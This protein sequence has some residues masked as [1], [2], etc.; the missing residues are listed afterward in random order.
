MDYEASLVEAARR[1]DAAA[2]DTMDAYRDDTTSQEPAITGALAGALRKALSGTI[3]GLKWSALVMATSSGK[4]AVESA[5]GADILIHVSFDTLKLK[6][7]KGV[8][9]QAKR[10]EPGQPM[11]KGNTQT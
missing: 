1:A 2:W 5:T 10:Y 7:S 3:A 9:V 8:L 4:S 6:Y 11:T